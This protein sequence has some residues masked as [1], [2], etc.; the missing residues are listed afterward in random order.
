M[1]AYNAETALKHALND[2][3]GGEIEGPEDVI[4]LLEDAR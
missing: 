3:A 4:R 2:A 1:N